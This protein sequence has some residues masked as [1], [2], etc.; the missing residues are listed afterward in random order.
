LKNVNALTGVSE[1]ISMSSY[2][3]VVALVPGFFIVN[4]VAV[5]SYIIAGVGVNPI[6]S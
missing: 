3:F 6:I 4:L 2:S 5:I 1:R